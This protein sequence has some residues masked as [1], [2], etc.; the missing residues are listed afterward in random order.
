MHTT[1]K[2]PGVFLVKTFKGY[3]ICAVQKR[4]NRHVYVEKV[5]KGKYSW[6]TDHTYAKSWSETTAKKHL[7]KIRE[8]MK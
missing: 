5:Y 4:H 7:A 8:M 3:A 2:N 1:D 6:V